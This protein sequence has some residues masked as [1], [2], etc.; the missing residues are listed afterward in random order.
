M[1][2]NTSPP[3]DQTFLSADVA[4]L[5]GVSLRQLRWWDE[6]EVV[7]P[8]KDGHRR[9]YVPE[10]VLE[11]LTMADLRRK[12][13]SLQKVRRILRLLRR[14]LEQQGSRLWSTKSEVHL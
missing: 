11:I 3:G 8:A 9:L 1:S 4:R 5:S 13:L 14:E 6:R 2:P 10:Q 12:G 7:S